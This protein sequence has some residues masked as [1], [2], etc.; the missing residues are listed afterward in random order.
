[1][2]AGKAGETVVKTGVLI[3]M[4]CGKWLARRVDLLGLWGGGDMDGKED[5]KKDF[6]RR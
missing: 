4:G 2:G 1:M 3:R 6:L 5:G